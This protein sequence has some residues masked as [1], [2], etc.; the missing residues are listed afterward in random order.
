MQP[1]EK[2]VLAFAYRFG[3]SRLE[4]SRKWCYAL[5]HDMN[6]ILGLNDVK[7]LEYVWMPDSTQFTKCI[8]RE[9]LQPTSPWCGDVPLKDRYERAITLHRGLVCDRNGKAA[10]APASCL[11]RVSRVYCRQTWRPLPRA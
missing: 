3:C 1:P 8:A 5:G 11:R 9:W 6:R 7:K 10:G 2:P 4:R